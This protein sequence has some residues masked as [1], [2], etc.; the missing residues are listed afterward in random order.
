MI[1]PK[2]LRATDGHQAALSDVLTIAWSDDRLLAKPAALPGLA[3][4]TNHHSRHP[5][6]FWMR[7]HISVL[8]RRYVPLGTNE[9][10]CTT[11]GMAW[12][13]HG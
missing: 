7:G 3:Q 12:R 8:Q 5:Q 2:G 4:F 9:I 13:C 10:L 6:H 1:T 11:S